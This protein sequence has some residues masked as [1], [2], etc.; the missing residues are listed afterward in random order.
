MKVLIKELYVKKTL[1][2]WTY[3]VSIIIENR[4]HCFIAPNIIM[5]PI[6]INSKLS[7]FYEFNFKKTFWEKNQTFHLSYALFDY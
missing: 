7:C 2:K 1:E 3:D 4:A 5:C 6:K